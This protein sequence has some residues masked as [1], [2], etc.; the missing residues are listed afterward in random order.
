[1]KLSKDAE[2]LALIK[3][4]QTVT[5]LAQ[6]HQQEEQAAMSQMPRGGGLD[7]AKGRLYLERLEKMGDAFIECH[8]E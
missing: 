3:Y 7:A 8:C 5:K 2:K 4:G 6:E 1:M